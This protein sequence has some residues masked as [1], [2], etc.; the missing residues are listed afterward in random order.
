MR[1]PFQ[2]IDTKFK[3]HKGQYLFQESI[4]AFVLFLV[5]FIENAPSRSVI[6]AVIGSTT[7]ILFLMHNSITAG[8]RNV[9][10]G[11]L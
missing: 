7:F 1:L 3:V 11:H 10:G 9:I 6:V 5:F 2:I 4:A 8:P